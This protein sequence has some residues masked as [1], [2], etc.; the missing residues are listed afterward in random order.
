[1]VSLNLFIYINLPGKIWPCSWLSFQKKWVPGYLLGV[2]WTVVYHIHVPFVF[3]CGTLKL[4]EI[5][6]LV[7]ACH[8]IFLYREY[9]INSSQETV[10]YSFISSNS[11]VF[12]HHTRQC[13]IDSSHKTVQN[14]FNTTDSAVLIHHIRQCSTHSSHMT[15]QYSFITPDS[16]VFIHHTGQCSIQSS[17]QTVQ[18]SFT[19]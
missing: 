2:K 18:Y 11:A 12:V 3:K 16:A 17:H 8:W 10:Q 14:S 15:V 6:E 5:W 7:Q 4:L 1:M 13:S 9:S 19:F